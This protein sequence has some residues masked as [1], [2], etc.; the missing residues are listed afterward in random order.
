MNHYQAGDLDRFVER[1]DAVGGLGP[2]AGRLCEDFQVYYDTKVDTGLDPFGEAYVGQ[3]I[4][5]YHELSGRGLDQRANEMTE[6]DIDS[7]VAAANPYNL[8]DPSS[9]VQHYLRIG[10]AVRL[11]ALPQ[12]PRVLDMGAG[13]GLT[14]EF[15]ATLGCDVT[16]VDINPSFV[17]LVRRR[18]R[19]LTLPV[20]PIQGGFDDFK[21]SGQFDLVLFYESLHHAVRPWTVIA[22]CAAMLAPGGKIAF[23]GEPIQHHWWPNWGIR[24]DPY[25]VYCIRKF[26]WFESGWSAGFARSMFRHAGL[27]L[28]LSG[29]EGTDLNLVGVAGADPTAASN[30][31]AARSA[32]MGWISDGNFLIS[33]GRSTLSLKEMEPGL[34]LTLR[35]QNYRGRPL[36]VV[37]R[38]D[39]GR[40]LATVSLQPG[41]SEV[42]L[43]PEGGVARL[44]IDAETWSPQEELGSADTRRLSFHL[45]SILSP[46][47]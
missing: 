46:A 5:L 45:V 36:Q 21:A 7:H 2:A 33:E 31:L 25:S 14:T 19:R 39:D 18:S 28:A 40:D 44:Q 38:N 32:E 6:F 47:T 8:R 42:T 34:G 17:E 22:R 3:Q 37:F 43:F 41:P 1:I 26:G 30:S 12:A 11:A 23:A 24:L 16:A 20:E 27:S 10:E 15:L 9:F 35:V 4:A 29:T 13:W